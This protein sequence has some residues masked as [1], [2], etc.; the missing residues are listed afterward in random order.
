MMH[1]NGEPTNDEPTQV[2]LDSNS[3]DAR[4]MSLKTSRNTILELR[5]QARTLNA[6]IQASTEAYARELADIKLVFKDFEL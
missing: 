5:R 2:E 1:Y 6:L 3:F 4:L